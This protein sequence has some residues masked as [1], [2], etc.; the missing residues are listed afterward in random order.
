MNRRICCKVISVSIYVFEI[1][2][3][4]NNC[5]CT[6]STDVKRMRPLVRVYH[7]ES[8]L[9]LRGQMRLF[10]LFTRR[11]HRTM[12][13]QNMICFAAGPIRISTIS[14]ELRKVLSAL[15]F[16]LETVSIPWSAAMEGRTQDAKKTTV[17]HLRSSLAPLS[18]LSVSGSRSISHDGRPIS[19]FSLVPPSDPIKHSKAVLPSNPYESR[20]KNPDVFKRALSGFPVLAPRSVLSDGEP[21]PQVEV[22]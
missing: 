16:R 19:D 12:C 2:T 8:L 4:A 14:P 22:R 9:C 15:S 21:P 3:E 5:T 1:F 13:P 6:A 11:R 7:T 10:R 18:G 20:I 17:R